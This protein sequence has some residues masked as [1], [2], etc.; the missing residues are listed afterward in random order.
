MCELHLRFIL[1]MHCDHLRGRKETEGT[2][3]SSQDTIL[4]FKGPAATCKTH[5]CT[6][7]PGK[8][9]GAQPPETL[10]VDLCCLLVSLN[11]ALF[12]TAC[13]S[14]SIFQVK[15]NLACVQ[16]AIKSSAMNNTR[17]IANMFLCAFLVN[18][19]R[20]VGGFCCVGPKENYYR[21]KMHWRV[22]LMWNLGVLVKRFY[23]LKIGHSWTFLLFYF[24]LL[25]IFVW[26]NLA[27]ISH[28]CLLLSINSFRSGP[29]CI[30]IMYVSSIYYWLS[31]G[32]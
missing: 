5:T 25:H 6:H 14:G 29:R 3:C 18:M 22:D 26:Q 24:E 21:Q 2:N 31:T 10:C 28:N 16:M 20:H 32:S 27:H 19:N 1:L 17:N 30:I 11:E 9:P 4:A 23:F 12:F 15:L 8:Q 7:N 13:Y